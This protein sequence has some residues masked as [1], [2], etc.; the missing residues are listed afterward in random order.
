MHVAKGLM[1]IIAHHALALSLS[2]A[3]KAGTMVCK[4]RLLL[5]QMITNYLMH[6]VVY[7]DTRPM[8]S[9]LLLTVADELGPRSWL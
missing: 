3:C 5:L 1:S 9:F 8:P 7:T 6:V 4:W 2:I